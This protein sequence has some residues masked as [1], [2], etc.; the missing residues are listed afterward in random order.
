MWKKGSM[1]QRMGEAGV[2][3]IL[4]EADRRCSEEDKKNGRTAGKPSGKK[5]ERKTPQLPDSRIGVVFT[6]PPIILQTLLIKYLPE[7]QRLIPS[8][9][10]DSLSIG[11]H[12]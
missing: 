6:L 1:E 5:E 11:A 10:N 4:T 8:T 2:R 7:P 12:G 3:L 9:R